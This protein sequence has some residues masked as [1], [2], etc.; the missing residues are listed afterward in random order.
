M[1]EDLSAHVLREIKPM[2]DELKKYLKQVSSDQI[3]KVELKYKNINLTKLI[4]QKE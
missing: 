2:R 4:N 3:E 1:K